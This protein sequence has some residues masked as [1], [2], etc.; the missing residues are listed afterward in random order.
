V[1]TSDELAKG[2]KLRQRHVG[3]DSREQQ[4][5]QQMEAAMA[6][7][8]AKA[9]NVTTISKG[10]KEASGIYDDY[11]VDCE[12]YGIRV[13]PTVFDVRAALFSASL[14]GM[15]GAGTLFLRYYVEYF[16]D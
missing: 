9:D 5:Q 2:S 8:S 14:I 12:L 15:V 11:Y 1:G 4:H 10:G 7:A 13:A 6:A 3:N 16:M